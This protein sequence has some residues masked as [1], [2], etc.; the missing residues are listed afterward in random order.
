MA[1]IIPNETTYQGD[2]LSPIKKASS[3]ELF[4]DFFEIRI[5]NEKYPKTNNDVNS[6]ENIRQRK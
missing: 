3:F 6:G 1:P 2:F 4:E 5:S